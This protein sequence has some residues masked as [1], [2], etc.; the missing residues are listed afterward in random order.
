MYEVEL[1]EIRE[2][3]TRTPNLEEIH[4]WVNFVESAPEYAPETTLES[5]PP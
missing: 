3:G 2:S 5:L 1:H 4:E